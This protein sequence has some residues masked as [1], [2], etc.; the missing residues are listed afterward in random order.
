MDE[1]KGY[2]DWLVLFFYMD[3]DM[4]ISDNIRIV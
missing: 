2:F 1:I 3:I 4:L